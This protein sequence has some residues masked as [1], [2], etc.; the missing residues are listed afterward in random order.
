MNRPV[1]LDYALL[2]GIGVI[3]GSQF[4]FNELA[5]RDFSSCSTNWRFATFRR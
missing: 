1:A 2:A 4:V 3:W 5:I